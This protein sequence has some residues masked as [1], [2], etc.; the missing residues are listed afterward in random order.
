[1]GGVLYSVGALLNL[2]GWPILCLTA[3]EFMHLC[4]M[5]GSLAHYLFMLKSVVPFERRLVALPASAQAADSEEFD[6]QL[7]P[8]QTGG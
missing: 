5:G 2:F 6:P 7:L 4:V 3:H 8:V 1:V